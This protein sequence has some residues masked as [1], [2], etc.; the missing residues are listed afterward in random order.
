[1]ARATLCHTLATP[2]PHGVNPIGVREFINKTSII[3]P[4][5]VLDVYQTLYLLEGRVCE[6]DYSHTCYCISTVKERYE[7]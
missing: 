1:M 7:F 3:K 5:K 4:Q 6:R 2:L